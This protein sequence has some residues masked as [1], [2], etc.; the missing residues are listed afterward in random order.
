L[1][2]LI[3][4]LVFLIT[5]RL[6]A[7]PGGGLTA[8]G[9]YALAYEPIV[10]T[11]LF[12]NELLASACVLAAVWAYGEVAEGGSDRVAA[13]RACVGGLAMAGAVLVR[14]ETA[15]FVPVVAVWMAARAAYR[16]R[17]TATTL[18]LGLCVI[19]LPW[20][21]RNYHLY[22]RPV[23][24]STMGGEVFY[25]GTHP[26][27]GG[28]YREPSQLLSEDEASSLPQD[29]VE[30]DRQFYRLGWERIRR[31]P[32]GFLRLMLRKQR[33]LWTKPEPPGWLIGRLRGVPVPLILFYPLAVL[34]LLGAGLTWSARRR[35]GLIWGV[36]AA[37]GLMLS[38]CFLY[39]GPRVR[40]I[41]IP[42]LAV[43]AGAGCAEGLRRLRGSRQER[44][45]P[46]R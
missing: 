2:G 42:L 23:F 25:V 13:W 21:V 44:P 7:S 6:S 37:Y 18:T 12:Y 11:S 34:G 41:L 29:P 26:A 43:L 45:D 35:Y 46:G 16:F 36:A 20:T 10:F 4:L 1:G 40:I 31:D 14:P 30:R 33:L 8:A 15:V 5:R 39:N 28:E 24:I 27:A 32:A 3:T 38:A 19:V 22:Q 9:L 17:V